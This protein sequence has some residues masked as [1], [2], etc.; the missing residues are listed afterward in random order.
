[1]LNSMKKSTIIVNCASRVASYSACRSAATLLRTS[2]RVKFPAMNGTLGSLAKQRL[3]LPKTA[4][5][6]L[7]HCLM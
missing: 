6:W 3:E 5:N 2:A 7:S 1:M 4:V